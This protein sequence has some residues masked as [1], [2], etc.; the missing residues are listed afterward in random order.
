MS[1][2]DTPPPTTPIGLTWGVLTSRSATANV[3]LLIALVA[4]TAVAMAYVLG[5]AGIGAAVAAAAAGTGVQAARR[6]R[7]RSARTRR[8]AA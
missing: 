1:T 8:P 5:P 4:A 3:A 7:R 2:S 6:W